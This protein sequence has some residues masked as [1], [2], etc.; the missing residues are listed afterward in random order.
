MKI[1]NIIDDIKKDV[2][3]LKNSLEERVKRDNPRLN[4]SIS[5]PGIEE[6]AT[7]KSIALIIEEANASYYLSV[8]VHTHN[9]NRVFENDPKKIIDNQLVACGDG[10][11]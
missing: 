5:L 10:H 9:G 1:E 4:F 2:I 3:E 7:I 6:L 8:H 11:P